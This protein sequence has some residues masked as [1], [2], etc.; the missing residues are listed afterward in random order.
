MK[1]VLKHLSILV[2]IT[3]CGT[4]NDTSIIHH[5]TTTKAA[6]MV[7]ND[8]D[9]HGCKGSAGYQWSKVKHTCI[10][11]FEDGIRLNPKVDTA[12]ATL[13][14]FV[15]FKSQE[16][17]DT[18]ELFLPNDNSQLL[19]QDK[20]NG[21]GKWGNNKYQLTQWKGMYTLETISHKA[22]IYQGAS[23]K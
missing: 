22:I 13:S 15:V 10:R 3:A 11:V 21:A 18:A 20:T 17:Q 23:L 9:A 16:I 5:D 19:V 2:I 1:Q 8:A 7:G 14:A 6:Q 12:S 4:T